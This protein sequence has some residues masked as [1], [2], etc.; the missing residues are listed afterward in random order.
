M[1]ILDPSNL[2]R[3]L[4]FVAKGGAAGGATAKIDLSQMKKDIKEISA[5]G[6]DL[7]KYGVTAEMLRALQSLIWVEDI[8]TDDEVYAMMR[9]IA[10]KTGVVLEPHG[11]TAF[12]ATLRAQA[13]KAVA[14]DDI[15]VIFETAH[16]DKFPESLVAAGIKASKIKGHAILNTIKRTSFAKLKKPSAVA[17]DISLIVDRMKKLAKSQTKK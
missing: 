6:I 3:L 12:I 1:D 11:V 9:H 15:V 17:P 8:E 14:S 10:E 16:P 7:K 5:D 4:S 13:K 2:E